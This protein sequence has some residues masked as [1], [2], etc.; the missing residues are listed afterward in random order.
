MSLAMRREQREAFLAAVHV[1]VLSA[2]ADGD[3]GPLAI[4]VWYS[5]TPGGTVNV[6]TGRN[7]R[8]ARLVRSGGRFTICVQTEA[9]PYQ[10]VT[11]EGPVDTIEDPVTPEERRAMAERYLGQ[12]GAAQYI[13][14]TSEQGLED[15]VIRMR[16]EHWLSADFTSEFA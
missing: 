8:K 11:A 3:R 2:A 12:A 10:Y 15:I 5:Y 13:A 14:A 4:P 6:I 16:P 7:S 9:I 1:G